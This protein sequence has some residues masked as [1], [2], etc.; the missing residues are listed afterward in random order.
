ASAANAVGSAIGASKNAVG[1]GIAVMSLFTVPLIPTLPLLFEKCLG[2]ALD[3]ND[4]V[5]GAWIGGSV[6]TTGAVVASADIIGEEAKSAAATVKMLQNCIIGPVCLVVALTVKPP[7][8]RKGT[9]ASSI[10]GRSTYVNPR[11]Q[12]RFRVSTRSNV[13]NTMRH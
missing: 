11:N 3:L 2:P 7:T 9:S 12:S 5:G 1:Y 8:T 10:G 6:D 13:Q 4:S